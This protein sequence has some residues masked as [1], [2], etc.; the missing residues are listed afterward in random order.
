[1][2]NGNTY[3]RL[4]TKTTDANTIGEHVPTWTDSIILYGWLDLSNGSANHTDFNAKVQEST[5]I[6]LCDYVDL[7]GLKA[8]ETRLVCGNETYEVLTIDDPMGMH[9]Q[10]EIYLRFVG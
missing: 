2:I 6:F 8:N 10:L 7:G 1:M 3:A 5:H 9:R 4:Q